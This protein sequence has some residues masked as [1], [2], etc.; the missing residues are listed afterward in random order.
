MAMA[1]ASAPA[2]LLMAVHRLYIW[3]FI[4]VAVYLC[5][6]VLI[7][8]G[9]QRVL[10]TLNATISLSLWEVGGQGPFSVLWRLN[11]Q[12][13]FVW[14]GDGGGARA[15]HHVRDRCRHPCVS[16]S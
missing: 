9:T 15:R 8:I 13:G 14:W 16:H 1:R 12:R 11:V 10:E 3:I 4:G 6:V 7:G 5:G 2:P